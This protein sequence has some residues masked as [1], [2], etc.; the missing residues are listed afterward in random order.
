MEHIPFVLLALTACQQPHKESNSLSPTPEVSA[1]TEVYTGPSGLVIIRIADEQ[2][3]SL[4]LPQK[5]NVNFETINEDKT[6]LR[7]E[8]FPAGATSILFS[9][10]PTIQSYGC[11]KQSEVLPNKIDAERVIICGQVF[12]P[13]GRFE[14]RTSKLEL[15]DAKIVT[16]E[17]PF[18]PNVEFTLSNT[19]IYAAEIEVHGTNKLTLQGYS[20]GFDRSSAHALFMNFAYVSGEGS[21]EVLSRNQIRTLR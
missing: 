5:L 10:H 21:F 2:N 18:D 17:K 7:I 20:D 13:S 12:I 19:T 9:K 16:T 8:Q 4:T 1:E 11:E 6:N 3:T 15:R 14:I